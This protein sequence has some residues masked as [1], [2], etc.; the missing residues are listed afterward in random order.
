M[1]VFNAPFFYLET[2]NTSY[3]IRVT[4]D[5]VLQHVY[6][7][8]KVSRDDFSYY[9]IHRAWPCDPM[10]YGKSDNY[11]LNALPQEYPTF[12]R[13]DFRQPALILEDNNEIQDYYL[14][15]KAL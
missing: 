9:A 1:I 3:I 11:S 7:G 12:G 10:F 8:K 13:G 5:G 15:R 14:A 2:E 6:Y 4:D